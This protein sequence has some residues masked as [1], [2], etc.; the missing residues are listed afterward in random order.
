MAMTIV[1]AQAVMILAS[2]AAMRM[3]EKEGLWLVLLISFLALRA[4]RAGGG[5][6][7]H[8]VGRISRSSPRR[9]RCRPAKWRES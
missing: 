4:A 7:H 2:I 6:R 5:L 8:G 3:S 9:H 1:V